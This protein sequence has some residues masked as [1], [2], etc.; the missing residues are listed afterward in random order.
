MLSTVAST[1]GL[2]P[3]RFSSNKRRIIVSVATGKPKRRN[4]AKRPVVKRVPKAIDM[5]VKT[6]DGSLAT[7]YNCAVVKKA[8]VDKCDIRIIKKGKIQ[9][10]SPRQVHRD[11]LTDAFGETHDDKGKG[12]Y[13]DLNRVHG[14]AVSGADHI[15]PYLADKGSYATS[16]EIFHRDAGKK[17]LAALKGVLSRRPGKG[18]RIAWSG[19]RNAEDCLAASTWRNAD[20][21]WE[22][23]LRLNPD[24]KSI[25]AKQKSHRKGVKKH[26][27]PKEKF[28]A[29]L[30]VM[31]RATEIFN[32]GTGRI[33]DDDE[34]GATP[35]AFPLE[36]CGFAIDYQYKTTGIGS[37]GIETGDY[38]YRLAYGRS[39]CHVFYKRD[40][41][42]EDDS[43]KIAFLNEE[44]RSKVKEFHARER[45]Q[46]TAA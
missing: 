3:E 7:R 9:E 37:D 31:R 34:G 35:Y 1:V 23:A 2:M 6:K 20:E 8:K 18:H 36:Q 29:N 44:V 17:A 42:Y 27:T 11:N 14:T 16:I 5:F 21:M 46:K 30:N 39:R 15:N 4:Q 32:V 25:L 33:E 26:K 43:S 45:Q 40:W 41:K 22:L 12:K 10:H 28:I 13:M 38:F 24:L 19:K